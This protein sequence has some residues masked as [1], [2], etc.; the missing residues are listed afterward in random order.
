MRKTQD[1]TSKVDVINNRNS[2]EPV[3]MAR[4]WELSPTLCL[5]IRLHHDYAILHD[6]KV[7]ET[8]TRLLAMNLIA[9]AAIQRFNFMKST[10]WDKGS[11][12][13]IYAMALSEYEVEDWID[14]LSYDLSALT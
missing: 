2:S 5:S 1:F 6:S 12:A 4:S 9:E 3:P 14:R 11:Q 7:P 13:A 10:E 8:V